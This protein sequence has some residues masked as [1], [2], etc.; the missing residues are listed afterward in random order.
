MKTILLVDDT[1][2]NRKF[3]IPAFENNYFILEAESGKDALT[4]LKSN[5]VDL[6]ITDIFMEDMD[7]YELIRAVRGNEQIRHIPVIAVTETDEASQA[8]AIAA[9]A[10]YFVSRPTKSDELRTEVYRLTGQDSGRKELIHTDFLLQSLP[11]AVI[12]YK[13]TKEGLEVL[14]C[15][16][17]LSMLTGWESEE[18]VQDYKDKKIKK[19]HPSDQHFFYE[20]I[21]RIVKTKSRGELIYRGYKK[22]GSMIWLFMQGHYA[23]EENGCP[24]VECLILEASNNSSMYQAILDQ[25]TSL[26]SIVDAKTFEVL[27]ANQAAKDIVA[28]RSGEYIGNV[29]YKYVFNLEKPCAHCIVNNSRKDLYIVEEQEFNGRFYQQIFRRMLWHGKEAIMEFTTDITDQKEKLSLIKRQRDMQDSILDT[30]PAGIM[31]FKF[32]ETGIKIVSVNKS[33]C[34][35]M[36]MDKAKALGDAET[37]ITALTH[38]DDIQIVLDAA[39]KLSVEGAYVEYEYRHFY[40]SRNDYVWVLGQGRSLRNHDG[41][42]YAYINYTDITARKEV[43][44]LQNK[45]ETAT[46]Q[47]EAKSEFYSQ[48]S[49]DMRTPMNII[50]GLADIALKENDV[51]SLH[52]DLDKIKESGKYMLNLINDTLDIQ[53]IEGGKLK[54]EPQVVKSGRIVED[55]VTMVTPSVR[56][57]NLTLN[58][59]VDQSAEIDAFVRTD[60]L[61]LKQIATNILSNSIKYTHTGGT[62]ELRIGETGR[63]GMISH[64][65]IDIA[66]NG[67]GMSQDFL[68]HGIF[69]PFSQERNEM[70]M[71]YPGSGLGLS[72]VKNLV[73]MMGGT[74]R[75]E[76]QL[77]EGTTFF[78]TLDL[79]LVSEKEAGEIK[80]STVD[81]S[82]ELEADMEGRR[83]LLC[84]DHPLNAEIV[85][86]LLGK[87]GCAVEWAENGAFGVDIF[88]KSAPGHFNAILMDIRMPVMDGLEATKMIRASNHADAKKI[89]IIA[90]SANAYE[91][92][93]Q[94][95]LDAGMNDHLAKPV[96]PQLL[97]KTLGKYL[98][99]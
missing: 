93:I 88:C 16:R 71:L 75:V 74:I 34:E 59:V 24:I 41:Y 54:L 37:N 9:G 90:M 85:Q 94:K 65:T 22:D 72:I 39:R 51:A 83:I 23:G 20:T 1:E 55:I 25:S 82:K 4:I 80:D 27:Y 60:V 53:R 66:D 48:M 98:T 86:R 45:L 56:E 68:E 32:T 84:E 76:S 61:R 96:K 29:C 10:D 92:D 38:P 46:I 69:K 30:I 21:N 67:V 18:F 63:D 31:V 79:E 47:A 70:S 73:E 97:F 81:A 11:G 5:H 8:E 89:P 91:E 14:T 3:M 78:I 58:V 35:M 95:S 44:N 6:I 13:V 40:R 52:Q 87:V 2:L 77:G 33:I 57:K 42:I 36:G 17:G 49:H 99:K 15:S 26:I 7:G 19:I 43:E 12:V 64:V 62:I 28:T 50:L